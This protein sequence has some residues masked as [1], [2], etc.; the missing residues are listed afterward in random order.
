M[1]KHYLMIFFAVLDN[2]CINGVIAY[3]LFVVKQCMFSC[4]SILSDK[5]QDLESFLCP[6]KCFFFLKCNACKEAD[7]FIHISLQISFPFSLL[8]EALAWE[9]TSCFSGFC[10]FL[11]RCLLEVKQYYLVSDTTDYYG[12]Y[13]HVINRGFHVSNVQQ[14]LRQFC[15]QKVPGS[16]EKGKRNAENSRCLCKIHCCRFFFRRHDLQEHGDRAVC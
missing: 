7:S 10:L 5:L 1:E 12:N 3:V 8:H 4:V 6:L 15:K 14:E 16:K 2:A 9:H 13:Y 11:L